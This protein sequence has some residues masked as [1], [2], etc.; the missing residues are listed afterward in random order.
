MKTHHSPR[1]GGRHGASRRDRSLVS[2]RSSRCALWVSPCLLD[3]DTTVWVEADA[4][5]RCAV[6]CHVLVSV[7][8]ERE[9]LGYA[10]A[11]HG[12]PP[13][14]RLA[15]GLPRTRVLDQTQT[16]QARQEL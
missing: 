8:V 5:C 2:K 10:L 16:L 15:L 1:R 9:L 13:R 11:Q 3:C 12:Q 4:G 7:G 14:V 6:S